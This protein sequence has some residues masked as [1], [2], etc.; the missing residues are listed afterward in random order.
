MHV[1]AGKTEMR[2]EESMNIVSEEERLSF[3]SLV[4]PLI[5]MNPL[6]QPTLSIMHHGMLS[7]HQGQPI[8]R[9][10]LLNNSSYSID[11]YFNHSCM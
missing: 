3:G 7:P 10:K 1:V 4:N 2:G 9:R 5:L 6:I 8:C 11:T